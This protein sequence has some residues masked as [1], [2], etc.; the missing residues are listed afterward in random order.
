MICLQLPEPN[1][2]KNLVATDRTVN[3]LTVKWDAGDGE[4]SG[5]TITISLAGVTGTSHTISGTDQREW[6]FSE[7]EAAGTEYTV[8]VVTNSGD[9]TSKSLTETFYTSKYTH[10]SQWS[11]ILMVS[12]C[13][14]HVLFTLCH[15]PPHLTS[16]SGSVSFSNF[17]Y[18]LLCILRYC[19]YAQ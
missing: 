16:R 13:V 12:L 7:L 1:K 19:Y 15:L 2:A 14:H 3:S 6:T 8:D 11:N 18:L 10:L 4:K 9:Q 17:A 5:F